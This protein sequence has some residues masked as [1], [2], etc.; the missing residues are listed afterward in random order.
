M[1]EISSKM[2]I[3]INVLNARRCMWFD[4]QT[5]FRVFTSEGPRHFIV[6]DTNGKLVSATKKNKGKSI[7]Q[8]HLKGGNA[9]A[10]VTSDDLDEKLALQL[11]LYALM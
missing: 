11:G 5:L 10:T 6:K 8:S 9:Y 7:S 4:W 1:T 3:S 2:K